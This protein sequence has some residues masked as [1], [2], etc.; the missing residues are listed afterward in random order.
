MHTVNCEEADI[1]AL[2]L[3]KWHSIVTWVHTWAM[4]ASINRKKAQASERN[5]GI[6][7]TNAHKEPEVNMVKLFYFWQQWYL[8]T[9]FWRHRLVHWVRGK[10]RKLMWS[11]ILTLHFQLNQ[12]YAGFPEE[13][14]RNENYDHVLITSVNTENC[15]QPNSFWLQCVEIPANSGSSRL[16][17]CLQILSK[18]YN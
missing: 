10:K 18:A 15:Q 3:W 6:L 4:V 14:L 2:L 8:N 7:S 9:L 17:A 5:K 11:L 1:F 13:L 16:G 12:I